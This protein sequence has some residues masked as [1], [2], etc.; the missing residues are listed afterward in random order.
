[1][2]L[3]LEP[4]GCENTQQ[5]HEM[6]LDPESCTLSAAPGAG[7]AT[8]KGQYA[9]VIKGGLRTVLTYELIR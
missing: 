2:L 8:Y 7:M 9:F 4:I 1:V 3:Y 6:S 5:S